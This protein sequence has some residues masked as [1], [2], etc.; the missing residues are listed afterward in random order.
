MF[1][2]K[3]QSNNMVGMPQLNKSN[4]KIG[5]KKIKNEKLKQRFI[6]ITILNVCKCLFR[7]LVSSNTR[8]LRFCIQRSIDITSNS[9]IFTACKAILWQSTTARFGFVAHRDCQSTNFGPFPSVAKSIWKL[10]NAINIVCTNF[11]CLFTI[12]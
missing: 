12:S 1:V 8:Y 6:L 11:S 10:G 4:N 7:L 9:N 3:N 2:T 5:S